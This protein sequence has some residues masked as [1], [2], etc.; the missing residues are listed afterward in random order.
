MQTN[1]CIHSYILYKPHF[2]S[3]F[4]LLLLTF[5][6]KKISF[7][8]FG[9]IW[10]VNWDIDLIHM[11]P[12]MCIYFVIIKAIC[13]HNQYTL[14]CLELYNISLYI[15]RLIIMIIIF[16][17]ILTSQTVFC[18]KVKYLT[19]KLLLYPA[20][21]STKI[22]TAQLDL[23]ISREWIDIWQESTHPHPTPKELTLPCNIGRIFWF[24]E[25]VWVTSALKMVQFNHTVEM[26]V[27]NH[28]G[29]CFCICKHILTQLEDI[30][31]R[32][33]A[34]P[35]PKHKSNQPKFSGLE[36]F[37]ILKFS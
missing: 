15:Y 12:L 17:T 13:I 21:T 3:S 10:N 1:V 6:L 35:W 24:A 4:F 7:L 30:S 16:K 22:V 19:T 28:L 18:C 31:R 25:K 9:F 14:S 5:F 32:R 26:A 20:T 36:S 8:S 11:I 2:L 27:S 34:L 33:N 29:S 23:N 37:R